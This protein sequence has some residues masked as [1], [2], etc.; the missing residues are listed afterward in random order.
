VRALV[1]IVVVATAGMRL[2]AR[3][4]WRIARRR[5]PRPAELIAATV[6]DTLERLGPTFIKAG[7]L[8]S[9]RVDLL[10]RSV[11]RA[12]ARHHDQLPSIPAEVA[13]RA[14]PADLVA[15]LDGA[16]VPA[17]AGSI[18]CVY[19]A[20]LSDGRTVAVKVRRPGIEGTVR[21]D[22]A[23]MRAA[24]GALQQLPGLRGAPLVDIVT[25]L[26]EA[27]ERQLDLVQEAASL[28]ALGRNLADLPGVRVPAV[29]D[30]YSGP[31]VL[32][33]HYEAG[34]GHQCGPE[35][36]RI[37][38]LRALRAVYQMLFLDGFVHCDLHPGNLYPMPDGSVVIVDAGFTRRLSEDARRAFAGFFYQMSR[39]NGGACSD[40]VMS[41]ARPAGRR[42]DPAGF[43]AGL[44]RLVEVNSRVAVADFDLVTFAVTLFRLQRAH[45]YYADPQFAF[46]ILSL[47]VLEGTLRQLCPDLDFQIEALPYVL[48]GLMR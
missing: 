5:G 42:A 24:A 15:L 48:R 27:I 43:R 23:L 21:R 30:T 13:T 26:G 22:L 37:A 4:A 38:A 7:Q 9:T 45:G 41:T 44:T 11:C 46:P 36:G 35:A 2:S 32:V 20:A 31:D 34:L 6:S 12:L 14:M 18:A 10:P 3:L 40:I 17:G 47:L 39:G 8:L 28:R 33:M 1:V 16:P 29:V 25:Q 19:R